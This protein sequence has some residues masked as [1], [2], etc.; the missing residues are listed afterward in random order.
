VSQNEPL[1][2]ALKGLSHIGPGS[3]KTPLERELCDQLKP[4][5]Q[6]TGGQSCIQL[7]EPFASLFV[8]EISNFVFYKRQAVGMTFQVG[9]KC[10]QG[11]GI[12]LAEY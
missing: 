11:T 10:G 5:W 4:S 6:T 12:S 7:I 2:N 3:I 8:G 1:E 9:M